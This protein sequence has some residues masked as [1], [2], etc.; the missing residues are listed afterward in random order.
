LLICLHRLYISLVVI[1]YFYKS[2]AKTDLATLH[3]VTF[4]ESLVVSPT[5]ALSF[6]SD[7]LT[8]SSMKK[9]I[10]GNINASFVLLE[11]HFLDIVLLYK[12]I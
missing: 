3:Y 2:Y 9:V 7:T 12:K 11:E 8:S 1:D 5:E 6:D 4:I 10:E